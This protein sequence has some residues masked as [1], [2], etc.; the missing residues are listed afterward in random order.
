M[1]E[2]AYLEIK[3]KLEISGKAHVANNQHLLKPHLFWNFLQYLNVTITSLTE[4][5]GVG[6][7]KFQRGRKLDKLWDK[8]L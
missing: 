4:A 7:H 1:R 2:M 3:E 5:S 8:S 6:C